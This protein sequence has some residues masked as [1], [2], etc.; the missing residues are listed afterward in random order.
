[1]IE[2]YVAHIV[3][4]DSCEPYQWG[5]KSEGWRLLDRA[6]LSVIQERVPSGDRERRHFHTHAR[7]FFFVLD[8]EAVIEI[9]GVRFPLKAGQGIDVDPGTPHQF[10]NESSAAVSFLVISAPRSHGDRTDV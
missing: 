2:V 4:I 6:D 5:A 1:V 10:M 7:Q 9:D 8:G 3:D